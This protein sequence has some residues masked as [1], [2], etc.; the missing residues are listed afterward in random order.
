MDII[1]SSI[2][3]PYDVDKTLN[4]ILKIPSFHTLASQFS[5]NG[6]DTMGEIA[7]QKLVDD[8]L[9]PPF[10]WQFFCPSLAGHTDQT[11]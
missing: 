11:P 1:A 5:R 2:L 4:S 9:I 6:H 10:W 8:E 7:Q 3:S